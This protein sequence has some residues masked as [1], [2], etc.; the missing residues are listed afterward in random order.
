MNY[1]QRRGQCEENRS[2]A[3]RA[4]KSRTGKIEFPVVVSIF[5]F[6]RLISDVLALA[7]VGVAASRFFVAQLAFSCARRISLASSSAAVTLWIIV[8]QEWQIDLPGTMGILTDT[9]FRESARVL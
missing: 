5:C 7:D 3:Y 8:L 4:M 2:T 9:H 1:Q 6:L